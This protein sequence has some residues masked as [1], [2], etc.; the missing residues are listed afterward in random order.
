[1]ALGASRARVLRLVI[2]QGLVQFTIR[3]AVGL[4]L[5]V[6][7][8][9]MLVALIYGAQRGDVFTFAIVSLVL[10]VTALVACLVPAHHA[11]R[12]DP[13]RALRSE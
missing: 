2:R 9:R 8:A 4:L 5:A 13:T 3:L 11:T 6:G 7:L 12:I 10:S 1:M